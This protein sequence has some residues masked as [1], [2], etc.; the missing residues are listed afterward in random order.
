M[1]SRY[2]KDKRYHLTYTISDFAISYCE[3]NPGKLSA[4]QYIK[5]MVR[6]FEIVRKEIVYN[7]LHFKLPY[8]LGIIR[9]K[10]ADGRRFKTTRK[11]ID[12]AKSKLLKKRIYHLNLHSD[13]NFFYWYWNKMKKVTAY[14]PGASCYI[15]KPNRLGK[16]ELAEHIIECANNP[17]MRDYDC[18]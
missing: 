2:K 13:R 8:G 11:R 6:F 17:E 1:L 12:F 10:K 9:I 5:V 3:E 4:K 18:L 16:R 14:I 7:R 15:F